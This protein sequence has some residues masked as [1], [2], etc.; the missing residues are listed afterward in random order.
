M[1]VLIPPERVRHRQWRERSSP[2]SAPPN[3][4]SVSEWMSYRLKSPENRER[5]RKREQ[6]VEPVFG[7][8]K[9]ARG[10]R[11]FLLRGL[12]KVSALW[13][14]ECAAHNLLKLYRAKV[15]LPAAG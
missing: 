5:Y 3:G 2:P 14:L 4:A 7:Q 12:N 15:A 8:I 10:L 13:Q 9:Q 1:S 11:Q 6:S